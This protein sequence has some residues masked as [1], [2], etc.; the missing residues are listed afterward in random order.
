MKKF[1]FII[2]FFISFFNSVYF[3]YA[4]NTNA[5]FIPAN[6]WYSKDPFEEGDKIKIY[7]LI[8]NPD[9]KDMTGDVSFYDKE[10]LLGKKTFYVSSKSVKDLSIDWIVNAGDHT[11]FARIENAKFLISKGKYQDFY[12]TENETEKSLR[13]VSKKIVLKTE[14]GNQIQD[15]PK[16]I[17]S[18]TVDNAVNFIEDKTP[19]SIKTN[20][21]NVSGVLENLRKNTSIL[22]ENKKTEIQKEIKKLDNTKNSENKDKI[23]KPFKQVQVFF[24]TLIS[25]LFKNK[26]A[27]YG[28]SILVI[29]YILRFVWRKI[30]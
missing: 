21:I 11:I 10:T 23:Q 28:L 5:G 14:N 12:I 24:Y 20:I 22:S 8:F 2:I 19:E 29:F 26:L 4:Q 18:D 27:F 9:T 30:F 16:N 7:T 3:A 15:T 17:I 13:S 1:L 6:I 25:I